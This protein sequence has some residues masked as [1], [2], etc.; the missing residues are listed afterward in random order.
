MIKNILVLVS[1]IFIAQLGFS[2]LSFDTDTA[3]LVMEDGIAKKAKIVVSNSSGKDITLRWSLINSTLNDNTDGDSDVSNN[4]KLQFCECNTCYS[5]D[6][7]GLVTAAQ[8][9][10]PMLDG[11]SVEWYITVDPNGQSMQKGEWIIKVDNVTD[12]ITD[13]LVFY[14]LN[15][16]AVSEIS[17]NAEVTSYPNPASSEFIVNYEL[18]NVTT[19]I[20][21]IYSIVGSKLASYPLNS[22]AGSV[23]INTRNLQNGMYFYSIEEKGKRVFTQKFNVVH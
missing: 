8:C 18:T 4:W 7:S 16:L 12:N 23:N 20:L 5:N 19:P 22:M 10:D 6:F 17:F 1:A 15:P 13:T 14:A 3:T 2:Q 21:N 11:S 9:A